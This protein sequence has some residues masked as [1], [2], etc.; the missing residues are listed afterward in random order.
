LHGVCIDFGCN[1]RV[2]TGDTQTTPYGRGTWAL[3]GAGIDGEAVLLAGRALQANILLTAAA[4]LG[5][6]VGDLKLVSGEIVDSTTGALLLPLAELGRVAYFRP[7]TLPAGFT[8]RP[9]C[10]RS[11]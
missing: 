11:L 5:R 10:G 3:R 2:V 6:D 9:K 1:V 7:D 8:P 4:I